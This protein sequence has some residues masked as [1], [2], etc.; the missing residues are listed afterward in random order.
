MK[1]QI[2]SII[3][4]FVSNG[5]INKG[6]ARKIIAHVNNGGK[7]NPKHENNLLSY[8]E[9]TYGLKPKSAS[10]TSAVSSSAASATTSS[11][12][13]SSGMIIRDFVRQTEEMGFNGKNR[14]D[15]VVGYWKENALNHVNGDWGDF[16]KYTLRNMGVGAVAGG[17]I[18]GTLETLQGGSFWTGAKEGAFNGALLYGGH[19]ALA[20]GFSPTGKG[21]RDTYKGAISAIGATSKS[22]RDLIRGAA[23][24][25]SEQRESMVQ[26]S[27]S[28]QKI[29]QNQSLSQLSKNVMNNR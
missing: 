21:I 22:R 4:K 28:V 2:G 12:T 14:L 27:R 17:A 1:R 20:A 26:V 13:T 18:G 19:R 3:Q 5:Q 23:G 8:I 16:A 25:T 15:R 7:I 24:L 9:Q 10:S 11:A 29:M 6:Q